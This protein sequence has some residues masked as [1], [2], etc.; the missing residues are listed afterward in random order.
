MFWGIVRIWDLRK[1]V[2]WKI[3][4]LG[5]VG[6][7]VKTS[8]WV[9]SCIIPCIPCAAH[10]PI[11]CP[12]IKFSSLSHC[13]TTPFVFFS[14]SD[15]RLS[16]C[17]TSY[18]Q[19]SLL[20]LVRRISTVSNMPLPRGLLSDHPKLGEKM[21]MT[22]K[23]PTQRKRTNKKPS[24]LLQD[25]TFSWCFVALCVWT[26]LCVSQIISLLLGTGSIF[27]SGWWQ[28]YTL[29]DYS[30]YS[31]YFCGFVTSKHSHRQMESCLLLHCNPC[32][33]VFPSVFCLLSH[34]SLTWYP[35]NL[36]CQL[37]W[38]L[39]IDPLVSMGLFSEQD[40]IYM[41]LGGR[42]GPNISSFL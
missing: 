40:P 25:Q 10:T 8:S 18:E 30:K 5:H 33:P 2:V 15:G 4:P 27:S 32:P 16:F 39:R 13:K 26:V 14:Q 12:V 6:Q 38:Y 35:Q 19:N 22:I 41:C 9:L 37:Y 28:R 23:I 11:N 31:Y 42:V 1:A 17:A 29:K 24:M 20:L 36:F 21:L 7:N 34:P 3:A